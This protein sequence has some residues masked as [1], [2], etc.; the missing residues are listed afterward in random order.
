MNTTLRMAL[1]LSIVCGL[2]SCER[3]YIYRDVFVGEYNWKISQSYYLRMVDSFYTEYDTVINNGFVEAFDD[4]RLKVSYNVDTNIFIPQGSCI[5][6]QFMPIYGFLFP[7]IDLAGEMVYDELICSTY[8]RFEGYI[9]G[10][11]IYLEYSYTGLV[12]GGSLIIE[13]VKVQ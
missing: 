12:W 2:V 1:Y 10:D 9:H 8:E 13:G 5:E 11:S 4:K 3:K 6:N 7:E